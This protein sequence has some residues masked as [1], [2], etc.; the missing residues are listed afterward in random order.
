MRRAARTDSNQT[1]IIAALRKCGCTT[2]FLNIGFGAPDLLVARANRMWL[3]ELKVK[4]G[5]LR[6]IQEDWHR[7]WNA[8]VH[9]VRSVE[10]AI[11]IISQR[12]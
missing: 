2:L 12:A 8:K 10:E 6:K 7:N 1:E 9:V 3:M 4:D 11:K 5:K